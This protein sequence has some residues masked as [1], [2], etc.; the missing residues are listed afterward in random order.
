[1][2]NRKKG[3]NNDPKKERMKKS[4]KKKGRNND[5]R[6]ERTQTKRVQII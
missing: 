3:R 5:E 6:K 4:L 1:M 2:T